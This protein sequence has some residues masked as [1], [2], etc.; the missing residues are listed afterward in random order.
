VTNLKL[1]LT[2]RFVSPCARHLE[3][4]EFIWYRN[5]WNGNSRELFRNMQNR[6]F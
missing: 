6:I 3:N 2:A 1:F 4:V 5:I